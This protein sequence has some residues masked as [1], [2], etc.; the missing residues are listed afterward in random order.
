MSGDS[1]LA[2]WTFAVTSTTTTVV[3]RCEQLLAL[4]GALGV[5]RDILAAQPLVAQAASTVIHGSSL[6]WVIKQSMAARAAVGLARCPCRQPRHPGRPANGD[7][8]AAVAVRNL[9]GLWPASL[10]WCGHVN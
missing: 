8:A 7:Q 5:S 10:A 3:V 2:M 9:A 1:I 4:Q 6:D